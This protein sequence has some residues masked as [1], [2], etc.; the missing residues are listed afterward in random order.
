MGKQEI[1]GSGPSDHDVDR[2]SQGAFATP[3]PLAQPPA[4]PSSRSYPCRIPILKG[5][6][7]DACAPRSIARFAH[8][9]LVASM[10]VVGEHQ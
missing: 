2:A 8:G 9:P 6:D 3:S 5:G 1:S 10:A 7:R 4:L